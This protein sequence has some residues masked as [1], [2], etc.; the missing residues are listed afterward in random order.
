HVELLAQHERDTADD[1]RKVFGLA[2]RHESV[3]RHG[4]HRRRLH[5]GGDVTDK[6]F[7]IA[8]R[9]FQHSRDARFRR[10][11][12]WKA[13]GPELFQEEFEFVHW[14]R[15]TRE[16]FETTQGLCSASPTTSG[17]RAPDP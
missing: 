5:C 1:D 2:A 10:G 6:L 15:R 12:H 9:R 17:L 11:Y 16:V 8:R 13:V 4:A 3:D 14:L 7:G